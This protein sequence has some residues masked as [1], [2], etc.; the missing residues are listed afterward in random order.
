MMNK[1]Q[2]IRMYELKKKDP[3]A[4][5]GL[6]LLIPG[7]GQFY[8]EKAGQG[9]MVLAGSILLAL[10]LAGFI[11]W[12]VGAIVGLFQSKNHNELL[13]LELGLEEEDVA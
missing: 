12:P 3:W 4:A 8:S 13:L 9:I 11:V 6:G 2:K 10:V 7:G 1:Q 5:L